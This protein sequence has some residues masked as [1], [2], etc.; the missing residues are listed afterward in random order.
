MPNYTRIIYIFILLIIVATCTYSDDWSQWRGN[1]RDG[2]SKETHLLKEWPKEGPA[3][4]WSVSGLGRGYSSVAIADGKVYTIG[5]VGKDGILFAYDLNGKLLWKTVYGPEYTRSF[6]GSRS[7]PTVKDGKVYVYS[8]NAL[9]VCF[10]AKNGDIIW[11]VDT[12]KEY[13]ATLVNHGICESPLVVGSNVIVCPGGPNA[14]VAAF[15]KN[16]GKLAWK[17]D[18]ISELQG[19]N[20]TILIKANGKQIVVAMLANSVYGI[21]PANGKIY[22]SYVYFEKKKG[23]CW[24]CFT[25][26]Y[27]DGVLYLPSGEIGCA[28]EGFSI[29]RDN[30]KITKLWTLKKM[31]VHHGGVVVVDGYVYGT[32]GQNESHLSILC[33]NIQDGKETYDI[34]K[35]GDASI[36]SANGMLYVYFTN[37]T[38]SLIPANPKEYAPVSSFSI[39][40][41]TGEHWSHPA[42]SDG[43]LFIRHGDSMMVYN[44]SDIPLK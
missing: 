29:S 23:D 25:P 27:A 21:N 13:K 30:K 24:P 10:N 39:T 15:N 22:W 17:T 20:S 16:T 32:P 18:S 41:G 42:L 34:K 2:L 5:L 26:L 14:G 36:I 9:L 8:G 40:K 1:N 4:L 44:V 38:V 3:L 12:L 31:G 6:N 43:R 33:F 37:G 35:T 11:S 7:T 19:Y 28:A